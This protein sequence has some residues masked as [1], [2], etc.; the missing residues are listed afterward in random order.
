MSNTYPN[1]HWNIGVFP[2]NLITGIRDDA[3]K[4][5]ICTFSV[6]PC[7]GESYIAQDANTGEKCLI[8]PGTK[9]FSN[10]KLLSLPDI[11]AHPYSAKTDWLNFTFPVSDSDGEGRQA[12]QTPVS[13]RVAIS[14]NRNGRGKFVRNYGSSRMT[15]G[16][17]YGSEWAGTVGRGAVRAPAANLL[18]CL[19]AC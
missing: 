6:L 1:T 2:L 9:G 5:P 13:A 8:V 14:P 16:M 15:F 12:I 18:L 10:A 17:L 3:I 7:C 11:A 4:S 19:V